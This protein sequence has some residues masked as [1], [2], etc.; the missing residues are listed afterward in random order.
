M[1]KPPVKAKKP[2]K[3]S[4]PKRSKTEADGT[5]GR[6]STC[7]PEVT[8]KLV[9]AIES[10]AYLPQCCESIGLSYQ[11][12]KEWQ[13][14]GRAGDEPFATF[15]TAI[16]RALKA[17]EIEYV[18]VVTA[19]SKKGDAKAAQWMLTHRYSKRWADR[20]KVEAEIQ[21]T[22]EVRHIYTPV[23]KPPR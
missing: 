6:P 23:K 8:A 12:C 19:A 10:G 15:S 14:R 2:A 16:K 4:E 5:P 9:E 18:K 20:E 1:K 13:R 11:T 7:T 17:R 22:G 3:P 21:T